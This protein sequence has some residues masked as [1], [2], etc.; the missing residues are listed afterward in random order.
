MVSKSDN[1]RLQGPKNLSPLPSQQRPGQRPRQDPA[2]T[3]K[4]IGSTFCRV[5]AVGP[6]LMKI[7]R[8]NVFPLPETPLQEEP[9]VHSTRVC[10][11]WRDMPICIVHSCRV[12]VLCN[13]LLN[14]RHS[15]GSDRGRERCYSACRL[16]GF[17]I[18][19]HRLTTERATQKGMRESWIVRRGIHSVR[20]R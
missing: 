3:S 7:H 19:V 17:T 1:G 14:E 13:V 6:R 16:T 8:K 4:P 2:G 15:Y 9:F 18:P 11:N 12:Q 5:F 10:I 20:K